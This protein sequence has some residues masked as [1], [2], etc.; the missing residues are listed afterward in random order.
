M[1]LESTLKTLKYYAG[2]AD[3]VHG[4]TIEVCINFV[5]IGFALIFYSYFIP[6]LLKTS[7]HTRDMSHMVWL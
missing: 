1:T 6:R 2:W 7:S 3:K 4:E 5:L